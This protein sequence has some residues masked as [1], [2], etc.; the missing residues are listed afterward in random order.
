MATRP[1]ATT[2]IDPS[3]PTPLYH[4]IFLLLR[5]QIYG[6]QYPGGSFLPSEPDL[7]I[8]F[9]VSRIT[10]KRAL[11]ELAVAGLAVRE[12]GRG[13]RVCITP[14]S[15]SVRGQI[16]G[17]VHSLH[18]NGRG[19][20]EL[21]EFG[22]VPAPK[23]VA[24]ALGLTAGDKVQRAIRIWHGDEGPFS[25]LTTFVPAWLG[26][27]W[28][29]ADLKKKPLIALLERAGITIGRA[30]E[31][32]TAMLA[33]AVVA[34]RLVVKPGSPLLRITRTVFDT[35]NRAVEHL[36]AVYPPDRYTYSVSLER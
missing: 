14:H 27:A 32:I 11:D 31:Q 10:A 22:D 15:T 6:G 12:Q 34:P 23:H 17:L 7:S 3:L 21:L 26:R 28:T 19:S 4:Q 30:E 2:G 16:V 9:G 29:K 24:A 36:V 35:S 25:H 20:V 33:D 18:A 8:Q 5:E 13:T 1:S